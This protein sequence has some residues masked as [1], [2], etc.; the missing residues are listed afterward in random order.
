MQRPGDKFDLAHRAAVE[1]VSEGGAGVTCYLSPD[2]PMPPLAPGR[3]G[4]LLGKFYDFK[5]DMNG[6]LT[7]IMV[8]CRAVP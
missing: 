1:L 2:V 6:K 5:T 7:V 8:L 4:R 3:A